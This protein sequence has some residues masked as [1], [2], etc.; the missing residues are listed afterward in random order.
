[1]PDYYNIYLSPKPGVTREHIEEVLSISIDWMRYDDKC[2]VVYSTSNPEK[3]HARLKKFVHP[4]GFLWVV[5]LDIKGNFGFMPQPLWT[6]LAV[7]RDPKEA[8]A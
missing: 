4:D 3:W 1:M 2:W 5:K 8:S 6:W 7:K